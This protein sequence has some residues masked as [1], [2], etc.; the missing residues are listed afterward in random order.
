MLYP[1]QKDKADEW[2]DANFQIFPISPDEV[3]NAQLKLWR[4]LEEE[5][6][7][8]EAKEVDY[9]RLKWTLD[10]VF[11]K[12]PRN[13]KADNKWKDSVAT[14]LLHKFLKMGYLS[15]LQSFK[16]RIFRDS[17]RIYQSCSFSDWLR[18]VKRFIEIKHD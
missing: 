13:H 4:K 14:F 7:K 3:Q 11:D 10:N 1:F 8:D 12:H 9:Q 16:P 6:F 18:C 17:V 5:N 15:V 2:H